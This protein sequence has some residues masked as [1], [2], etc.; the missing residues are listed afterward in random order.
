[1][2]LTGPLLVRPGSSR[3]CGLVSA[4]AVGAAVVTYRVFDVFVIGKLLTA[5]WVSRKGGGG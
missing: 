3:Q 5:P 1:M 4:V 2:G